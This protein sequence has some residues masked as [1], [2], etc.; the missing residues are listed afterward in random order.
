[1]GQFSNI[2][3]R[4]Q[5]KKSIPLIYYLKTLS[6]NIIMKAF[7]FGAIIL[8]VS[9]VSGAPRWPIAHHRNIEDNFG[10]VVVI[11]RMHHHEDNDASRMMIVD[12]KS[13]KE[14]EASNIADKS[15]NEVLP[16]TEARFFRPPQSLD[17]PRLF[18]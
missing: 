10:A 13:I 5:T 16:P 15:S 2:L 6:K 9:T 18:A 7:V 4:Y 8:F 12:S 14:G 17:A 11:P 3:N 1:M